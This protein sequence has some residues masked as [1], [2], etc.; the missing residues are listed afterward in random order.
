[1]EPMKSL[2]Y[3]AFVEP[4]RCWYVTA[5]LRSSEHACFDRTLDPE[6]S[7]LEFFVPEDM[8]AIFLDV[9]AHMSE[10]GHVK[11]LQQLPNRL[12]NIKQ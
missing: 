2:Y 4:T 10:Q 11:N 9:M 7:I 3:Q 12:E 6:K 8:Q 5:I 1:M